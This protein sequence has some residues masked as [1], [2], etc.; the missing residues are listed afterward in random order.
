VSLRHVKPEPKSLE[1]ERAKSATFSN[2]GR[3]LLIVHEVRLLPCAARTAP[4]RGPAKPDLT[5]RSA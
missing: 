2:L 1:Q 3:E 5:L 4:L